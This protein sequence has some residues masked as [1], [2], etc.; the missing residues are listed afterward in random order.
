MKVSALI[1]A[2]NRTTSIERAIESALHQT[3]AVDEIVVVDDGSTDGTAELVESVYGSRVRLVRQENR[4][5]S[6]ARRRAVEEARGQWVAFLDS[7]DKWPAD[8]NR[9]LLEAAERVPADVA[10]IFGDL[11][12]ITDAGESETVFRKYG[13]NVSERLRVLED[14]FS[15]HMP[16]QFC[17]IHSSLIRRKALLEVNC[18]SE[19]LRHS[20]DFLVAMQV[21]CRYRFA[22][23]PSVVVHYYR[24]SDLIPASVVWNHRSWPDYYRAR[25]IAY[26]L[27]VESGRRCPWN[28]W[29]AHVVR[30]LC[31]LQASQGQHMRKLAR[32][33]FRYGT[34]AK[35]LGF[36]CAAL[37]GQ[38]GLR[39][40]D[41]VGDAYRTATRY[42][43]KAPVEELPRL[44]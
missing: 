32:E 29:H 34:S 3:L 22:A 18:F 24:T 10:W 25:M 33:Q 31:K 40:W 16:F 37:F 43:G 12:V 41:V 39:A 1:T 30:G 4:G 11:K 38:R 15:I 6:G 14:S 27:A 8:R 21:A 17:M 2:Y 42:L 26:G 44:F 23:I 19:G 20:E 36:Y 28:A 35:S 9:E 13:L 5:I 7:D